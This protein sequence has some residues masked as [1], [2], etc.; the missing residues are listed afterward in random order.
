MMFRF[1]LDKVFE[2]WATEEIEKILQALDLSGLTCLI[3]RRLRNQGPRPRNE[4]TRLVELGSLSLYS[5]LF[6]FSRD[7]KQ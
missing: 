6:P 1:L 3:L 5:F 2:V 4:I 7:E